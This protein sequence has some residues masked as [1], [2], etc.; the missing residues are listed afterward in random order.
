MKLVFNILEIWEYSKLIFSPPSRRVRRYQKNQFIIVGF[1]STSQAV[2]DIL[3][4]IMNLLVLRFIPKYIKLDIL[5]N[6]FNLL[7][8]VYASV[9]VPTQL[10]EQSIK[11]SA[12]TIFWAIDEYPITIKYGKLFASVSPCNEYF[13]FNP[14]FPKVNL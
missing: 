4:Y 5:I 2:R 7:L 6:I 11:L 1:A 12:G 13:N 14:F 8:N 10:T 3:S 9:Y